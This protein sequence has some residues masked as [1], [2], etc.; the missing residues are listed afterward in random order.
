MNLTALSD[1]EL[2]SH[3]NSLLGSQR[4]LTAKLVATLAEVEERR[5]H[6]HAGYSSMFD[7]CTRRLK[8]SEGEAYRRINAARLFK[9]FPV[10][11]SMIASG[12]IHLSAL[13]LLRERLTDENHAELLEA[14]SGKSK[15]QV[16]EWL[17]ARFP[18]QDVPS[19]IRKLPELSAKGGV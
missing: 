17:A 6:L 19:N 3:L 10:I 11:E 16:E 9:R 12:A 1:H 7:F 18:K 13:Q 4:E 5:L 14:A 15:K 8:L 2:L